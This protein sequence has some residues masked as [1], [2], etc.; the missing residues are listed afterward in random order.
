[1][2]AVVVFANK[3]DID[4]RGGDRD[5]GEELLLLYCEEFGEEHGDNTVDGEMASSSGSA[6]V[7][8]ACCECWCLCCCSCCSCLCNSC[9]SYEDELD[10]VSDG[11]K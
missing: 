3:R 8:V 2:S 4:V 5:R 11:G 7:I 10:M 9:R 1:M 6:K